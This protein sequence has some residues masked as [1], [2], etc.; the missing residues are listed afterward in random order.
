MSQQTDTTDML[1]VH[2]GLRHE[3]ARLP[4]TVKAV[5]DGDVD[6]AGVVGGH[7]LLML[8]FLHAHHSSEDL[9]IWPL[10]SE[11]V[12]MNA[13]L[14]ADMQAQH[15]VM[16][17]LADRARSE[18]EA[19]MVAAGPQERAGLHTTLIA[20]EKEL[21]HH[22]AVEEQQVLPLIQQNLTPEEYESV[23]AHSRAE[24]SPEQLSIVLGFILANTS[25]E[26]GEAILAPMPPEARAGFEQFGRP[27]YTAY[28]ARLAEY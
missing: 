11:R 28:R 6:R 9:I 12:P 25:V 13:E 27:A 5:S 2:D 19:W 22:L 14:I 4:I 8:D 23:G 26:R 7:V 1:A 17:P 20:L 3:L 21:L 24:F 10:L 16:V 18:A 15:D